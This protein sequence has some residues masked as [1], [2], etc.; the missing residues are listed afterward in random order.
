MNS[1]SN[2]GDQAWLSCSQAAD[3][4]WMIALYKSLW[5]F[6]WV[7][8]LQTAP[9]PLLMLMQN[10][11]MDCHVEGALVTGRSARHHS[12]NDLVWH[13]HSKTDIPAVREPSGLFR[14]DG[15]R[16]DGVTLISWKS[17][18]CMTWDVTVTNMT[19]QSYHHKHLVRQ[20]K[21]QQTERLPN[22]PH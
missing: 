3:Y 22:M 20:Q 14:T 21:R 4:V 12:M 16:P 10:G 13:A 17:G 11:C 6:D 8:H 7:Q 5:V 1:L 15:K 2:T 18:R 9:M 19:A